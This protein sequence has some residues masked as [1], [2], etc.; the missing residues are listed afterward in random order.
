M[1]TGELGWS[2][3]PKRLR[4]VLQRAV[5]EDAECLNNELGPIEYI[6]ALESVIFY[7]I[8]TGFAAPVTSLPAALSERLAEPIHLQDVRDHGRAIW[9]PIFKSNEFHVQCNVY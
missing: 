7:F 5:E 9:L 1:K 8:D 4:P 2:R 3:I 6:R